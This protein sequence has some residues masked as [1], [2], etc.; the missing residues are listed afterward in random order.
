MGQTIDQFEVG[1]R[2]TVTQQIPQVVKVW[3]NTITGTVERYE[4]QK[5][6]S[7]FAHAKDD[8]LWLD[9]LVLKLDDGEIVTL[10][11]DEYSRVELAD[12]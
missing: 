3:T 5:T 4:Q 10:N 9:R 1:Q 2:V 12:A 11:L 8:T 7:A 6:G